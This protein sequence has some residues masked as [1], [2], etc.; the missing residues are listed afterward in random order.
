MTP[1]PFPQCVPTAVPS[2]AVS[3]LCSLQTVPPQPHADTLECY[4]AQ[5]GDSP[6]TALESAYSVTSRLHVSVCQAPRESVPCF[7]IIVTTVTL[8]LQRLSGQ[9]QDP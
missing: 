8:F 1:R 7:A 6:G 2:W 9:H 4:W 3:P 5:G